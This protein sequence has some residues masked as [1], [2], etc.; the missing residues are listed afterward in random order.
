[1]EWSKKLPQHSA[2]GVGVFLLI[3]LIVVLSKKLYE[4]RGT[5]PEVLKKGATCVKRAASHAV[6]AQQMNNPL[7]AFSKAHQALAYL[8]I[9]RELALDDELSEST[10]IPLD[11][12]REDVEREEQRARDRILKLCPQVGV[13]TRAG[14]NAGYSSLPTVS[15]GENQEIRPPVASGDV[16]MFR[17]L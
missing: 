17:K 11:E 2:V 14:S 15:R 3:T 10:R 8:K 6:S 9:A 16:S 5:N 7:L 1:M 12:L 13:R 4:K